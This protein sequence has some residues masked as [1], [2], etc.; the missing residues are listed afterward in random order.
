MA[1]ARGSAVNLVNWSEVLTVVIRKGGTASEFEQRLT[2]MGILGDDGLLTLLGITAD[3]ARLAAELYPTTAPAGL[4]LGDRLC[5]ATGL[6]LRLPIVTAERSWPALDIAGA[7][8]RCIR[9]IAQ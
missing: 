3:D 1:L 4:S 5:Y 9:T 8:V 7:D 2:S 6:R